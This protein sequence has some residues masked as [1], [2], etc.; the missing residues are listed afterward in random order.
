MFMDLMIKDNHNL[1][2][3]MAILSH[4]NKVYKCAKKS[5]RAIRNTKHKKKVIRLEIHIV[6]FVLL[7]LHFINESWSAGQ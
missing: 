3:V 1:S 5:A 6:G 4:M 2:V 7:T